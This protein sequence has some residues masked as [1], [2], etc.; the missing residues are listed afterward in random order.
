MTSSCSI[1]LRITIRTRTKH[2]TTQTRKTPPCIWSMFYNIIILRR[3]PDVFSCVPNLWC[4]ISL[5]TYP[6]KSKKYI[7]VKD[8]KLRQGDV[9]RKI[10]PWVAFVAIVVLWYWCN[11][12]IWKSSRLSS[13]IRLSPP[14]Y[15]ILLFYSERGR[16]TQSIQCIKYV[17]ISLFQTHRYRCF[18]KSYNMCVKCI[19]FV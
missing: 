11:I 14:T 19:I 18:Y 8:D 13:G 7:F 1:P 4:M 10:K 5:N 16:I 15:F 3:V 12:R 17:C 2:S 9:K 6:F